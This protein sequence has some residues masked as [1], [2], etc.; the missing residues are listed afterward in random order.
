MTP[1]D[2]ELH[3]LLQQALKHWDWRERPLWEVT[4]YPPME[5][6]G[7]GPEA[8]ASSMVISRIVFT[9]ELMSQG[10]RKWVRF[11][12]ADGKIVATA[13]YV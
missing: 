13:D 6:A 2:D 12:T 1:T 5:A 11:K 4:W 8:V 3:E 7:P 10:N 9:R